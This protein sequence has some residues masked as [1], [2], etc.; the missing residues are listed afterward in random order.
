MTYFIKMCYQF[1]IIIS[2]KD[3][4]VNWFELLNCIIDYNYRNMVPS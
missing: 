3:I 1:V 4:V 2:S